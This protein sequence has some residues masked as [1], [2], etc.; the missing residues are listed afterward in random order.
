MH[1]ATKIKNRTKIVEQYILT[2]A[3]KREETNSTQVRRSYE[4]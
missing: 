1:A 3:T 4:T 2:Q